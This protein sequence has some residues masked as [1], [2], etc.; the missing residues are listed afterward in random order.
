MHKIYLYIFILYRDRIDRIG[1]NRS[2]EFGQKYSRLG[3]CH[4][5]FGECEIDEGQYRPINS[6]RL[7]GKP[8][9][10]GTSGNYIN[11]GNRKVYTMIELHAVGL[12]AKGQSASRW[13][14][15]FF[16]SLRETNSCTGIF[17]ILAK[18][19]YF[20]QALFLDRSVGV[21]KRNVW[22][23]ISSFFLPP[24]SFFF[25]EKVFCPRRRLWR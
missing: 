25:L 12:L 2:Y 18:R 14:F 11:A 8:C 23:T 16:L 3:E 10:G 9:N 21:W 19:P 5:K 22:D 1:D 20:W 7:K 24:P 13:R 17:Y 15:E 6:P 4:S